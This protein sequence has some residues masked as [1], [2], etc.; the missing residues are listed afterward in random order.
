MNIEPKHAYVF[1]PLAPTKDGKFYGVSGLDAFGCDDS[2]KGID[3]K[4]AEEIARFCNE[5]PEFAA[6]FIR[7]IKTIIK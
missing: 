6:S 4:T 3:K 5:N 7:G 2:I 1:Q